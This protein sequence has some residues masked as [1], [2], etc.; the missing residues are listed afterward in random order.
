MRMAE[1][2]RRSSTPP[3]DRAAPAPLR[4]VDEPPCIEAMSAE[5]WEM[6]LS[7]R[8]T[9]LDALPIAAA[10]LAE[11][12]A[13]RLLVGAC[14]ERYTALDGWRPSR[15]P[16]S[17]IDSPGMARPIRDFFDGTEQETR[18]DWRDGDQVSG[19]HFQ[20][21]ISRLQ[22][23]PNIPA[24]CLLTLVD[25]TT[26]IENARSLRAELL[27]DSLT[28][29]PNRSAFAEAVDDVVAAPR[30]VGHAVLLVDLS[31]FSR[32][33]ESLGGVA[34]D[35]VIIT[36]A[37]RLISTLRAGDML[38]R[39]GG[40]EFGILLRLANG[41]DD[42]PSAARRIQSVLST[43]FRLARFEVGLECAIGCAMIGDE[44]TSG[45]EL[46]RN[47]QFALKR[48]KTSGRVEVHHS[49]E[50][51]CA[52]YK[53][54]LETEL[55]RA[56]DQGDLRL[57]FQPI[58]DLGANRVAGFE[59]LA[60]WTHPVRG[61][62]DPGEFIPVAEEAGLIVPLGRWA[63][64]TALATLARW[65]AAAGRPIPISMSVNVSAI[66]LARDDVPG[67]IAAALATHGID[68][69]RLTVELT[70][71]AI[72][73]DPERTT[74]ALQALKSLNVRV[75]MD[76]FGTGYS[77][78]SY[79]RKLPIDNLKIDRSFVSGMLADRDKVAIVRAVLSLADALGKTTTAEGVESIELSQT[80]AAL[81]CSHGQGYF[82][83]MPLTPEAAHEFWQT[84]IG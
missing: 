14:N 52:R 20:V 72:V 34:G 33:N 41:P 58:M 1:A 13:G 78:L 55:R 9:Y 69:G 24:R 35:E 83:G 39:V 50:A 46:V 59:A 4:P 10:I 43:P 40:D 49:G 67:V 21:S 48:A 5:M 19:R 29:L 75:A 61:V 76:D 25:R 45:E 56:I 51:A 11:D 37:R 54:D 12:E 15:Q 60:R 7:V 57:A 77:S 64:D 18:F 74:R 16:V 42:A 65:D 53:L 3:V 30:G 68:G 32:I 73:Q 81:G 26:E 84:R 36:V 38:A 70:E 63:V 23:L 17:V 27:H 71:S 79:L 66:Q 6:M 2:S 47:A 8:Q 62:I 22:R 28:G 82:Y 80:L 44:R 31:R